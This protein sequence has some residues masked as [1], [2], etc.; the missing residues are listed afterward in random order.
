MSYSKSCNKCGNTISMIQIN[1]MWHAYDDSTATALHK[2]TDSAK[3]VSLQEKILSLE[4]QM[5]KLT[6]LLQLQS[7]RL[8]RLESLR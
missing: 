7:E 5:R 1:G 2:C 6:D 3:N 8:A 4:K